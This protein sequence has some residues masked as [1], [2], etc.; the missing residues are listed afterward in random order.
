MKFGSHKA[1]LSRINFEKEYH[2]QSNNYK[3]LSHH[4]DAE[5]EVLKLQW[6]VRINNRNA[7][8]IF[9]RALTDTSHHWT[10]LSIM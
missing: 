7:I 10:F 6:N 2:Q 9:L 4:A 3:K 8:P 1:D 5:L